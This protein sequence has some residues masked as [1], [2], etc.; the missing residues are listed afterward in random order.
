MAI[1]RLRYFDH[2]FLVVAD[3]KEE[4]DYH[5]E[6][7]RRLNRVLHTPGIAEGLEVVRT[8]NK[9][10]TV[11]PGIAIDS[12]GRE[13][14]LETDRVNVNWNKTDTAISIFI[15]IRY[16]EQPAIPSKGGGVTDDTRFIEEPIIEVVTPSPPTDSPVVLLARIDLE[17]GG[18]APRSDGEEFDGGVRKVV[19]PT[20]ER[21]PASIDGVSNPGGDIDLVRTQSITIDHDDAKSQIIIGET[22]SART[23]NPHATTAAQVGALVAVSGVMNPLGGGVDLVPANAVTVAPDEDNFRIIIGETHSARTNNPHATTAAQVGALVSVDGVSNPGGDIDLVAGAGIVI[24]PDQ[25]NRRVTISASSVL[26][27]VSLDGVSNPGGNI[28]LI[29]TQSIT[30][31][32]D[33][34]N[35][36]ITIGE[37]HS[38]Q[39]GNVHGLNAANLQAIG[40]MLASEYDLRHRTLVNFSLTQ[41]SGG[42]VLAP[43][44]HTVPVSVRP[45]FVLAFGSLQ[46]DLSGRVYGGATTGFFDA[47]AGIQRGHAVA[48]TLISILNGVTNWVTSPANMGNN[49]CSGNFAN[50]ATTPKTGEILSIS[51]AA[52]NFADIILQF[53]RSVLPGSVAISEFNITLSLLIMGDR[54]VTPGSG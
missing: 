34:A 51:I 27:P 54:L 15:I 24:A 48:V 33:D 38:A 16:A 5:K 13:M 44:P 45:S 11:K 8:S 12:L 30:I 22:H 43:G 46:V 4:Q 40:A 6:M 50:L 35:N 36:R 49:I 39:T 37:T 47:A 29:S 9:S 31:N 7:R 23:D 53:N 21:G 42:P 20:G 26:G 1:Q 28:D 32:P 41:T 10:V 14:V 17:A 2:Q 25:A 52:V 18:N 19:G 3:F